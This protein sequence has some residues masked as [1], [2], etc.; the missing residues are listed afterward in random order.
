[1]IPMILTFNGGC[2]PLFTYIFYQCFTLSSLGGRH[3]SRQGWIGITRI[4]QAFLIWTTWG[5]QIMDKYGQIWTI[6]CDNLVN[7]MVNVTVNIMDFSCTS[8]IWIWANGALSTPSGNFL[9]FQAD[10]NG[11]GEVVGID[12][13]DTQLGRSGILMKQLGLSQVFR[14]IPWH[15]PE[16]CQL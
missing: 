2:S 14:W 9:E 13:V 7:I 10:F 12:V 4:F 1:M 16:I 8:N 3:T 15:Q 11:D 5:Q 6:W